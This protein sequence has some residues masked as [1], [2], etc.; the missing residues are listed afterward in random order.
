[1]PSCEGTPA[2]E[3]QAP[4]PVFSGAHGH[5]GPTLLVVPSP[6]GSPCGAAAGGIAYRGQAPAP[7][8]SQRR[9][10]GKKE[11]RGEKQISTIGKICSD[12]PAGALLPL[13]QEIRVRVLQRKTTRRNT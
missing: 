10:E 6:A 9:S 2:T 12:S 11:K 7:A 8:Q 13:L 1:M 5:G 4:G 3:C